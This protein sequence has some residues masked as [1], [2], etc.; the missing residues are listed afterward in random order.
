MLAALGRDALNGG[1]Q[2]RAEPKISK[3][4]LL[5]DLISVGC[6]CL[7]RKVGCY[8]NSFSQKSPMLCQ[9]TLVSIPIGPTHH[10]AKSHTCLDL[11]LADTHNNVTSYF[12]IDAPFIACRD[13]ILAALIVPISR[14]SISD[15]TYQ[16]SYSFGLG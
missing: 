1:P 8:R 9:W 14:P 16:N 4:R 2:S 15:F 11:C 3:N 6:C 7:T 13:L 5:E 10:T 12:K